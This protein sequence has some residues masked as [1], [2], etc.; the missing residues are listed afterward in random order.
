M[1]RF[2]SYLLQKGVLTQAQLEQALCSQTV[3]GGRLGT[4]LLE[5]G[6]FSLEDMA[7][8]LTDFHD[9]PL[10]PP[11]WLEK[12]DPEA[13]KA[14]PLS[15]VRLCKILPLKL[16]QNAIHVAMLDP[17]NP[18]HLDFVAIASGREVVPYIVPEVRLLY[19]L[20][21]H[22]GIDRHP[23]Y[24][25][26][27]RRVRLVAPSAAELDSAT[28]QSGVGRSGEHQQ[29]SGAVNDAGNTPQPREIV[30]GPEEILLL[31]ELVCEPTREGAVRLVPLD[32]EEVSP[33]L[34]PG[35]IATLEAQLEAATGRDEIVRLALRIARCY[36]SA[37]AL[38]VLRGGS[39]NG[40]QA[41]GK[42]M[43]EKMQGLE[44][45]LET[46]SIF[47]HPAQSGHPFRGAPP[48]DGIDGRML[49]AMNRGEAPEVFLHPVAI[50]DRVVSVLYADNGSDPLGDTSVA[51]LA[52]LCGCI[53]RAYER[54]ILDGK[55]G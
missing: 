19:W 27:A 54:L 20:E 17:K 44:L 43:D 35:E 24:V 14:V 36:C 1:N 7:A 41:S 16:E 8:H 12:P 28:P 55:R 25:N 29:A 46:V 45:P 32:H 9:I 37:A 4:N 21:T 34:R 48:E 47:T 22:L 42:G 5:L 10:P 13:V 15:I 31:E 38:F 23:R 52:A 3:Y 18:E 26:L 40:F 39:L 51:A 33:D 6:D 50:R 2:G 49:E 53:S 30:E 11:E